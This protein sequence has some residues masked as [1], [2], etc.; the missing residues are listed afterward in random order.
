MS[1]NT[2]QLNSDF[3]LKVVIKYLSENLTL[4]KICQDHKISKATLHKWVITKH[5]SILI[6]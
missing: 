3:K 5:K 4:A 6:F 2:K 1:K